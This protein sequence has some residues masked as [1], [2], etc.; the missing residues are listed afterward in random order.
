MK[1]IDS[2]YKILTPISN[3]G[4]AE[5]H[6]I[7]DAARLCYKSS[8]KTE[9]EQHMLISGIIARG[10]EAMLEHSTLSVL[11]ICDRGISHELVRHRLASFAQESTRWCNYSKDRFG[12]EITVIRPFMFTKGSPEYDIWYDSCAMAEES[13]MDLLDKGVSPQFARSVLPNSLKTE[14][15]VTANYREWRKIFSLRCASDAHPQMRQ[16][17]LPLLYEIHDRIPVIFDDLIERFNREKD[18]MNDARASVGMTPIHDGGV[19]NE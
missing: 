3:R 5:L 10:H 1:I 14:I 4:E 8:A 19:Q 9:A 2:S 6:A 12:S 13:Y 18:T 16:L 7:E 17:M 15:V 11:F